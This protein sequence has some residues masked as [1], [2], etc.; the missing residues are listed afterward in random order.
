MSYDAHANFALAAVT[1]APIPAASGTSLFVSAAQA[2]LFP[3]APFN[4]TTWPNGVQPLAS[5]AEIVRVTTV[6]GGTG[7]LTIVRAQEG[8]TAKVIAAGWQIANTITAKVIEDIEA[9]AA[10]G[11]QGAQGLQGATGAQGLQGTTGLQGPQGDAGTQGFQG[12]Q[13]LQGSTGAQGA[14]GFQGSTGAQGS[15]GV[16]GAT[17][18]Q[19]AQGFQGTQGTQGFQGPQGLQGNQGFQGTQGNQG[20]QGT[21]G[22]SNAGSQTE[23]TPADPAATT[24]TT[25]VMM[26]L[27]GSITPTGSGNVLIVITGDSDNDTVNDGA[28]IGIR[29][30][31]GAAP[32][33]GAALTG[34]AVGSRPISNNANLALDI[35]RFPFAVAAV[36]TGLSV[37]TAY[38]VDASVAAVTGGT[39]RVRNLNIAI[40]E[41]GAG[42]Q[43]V[44]GTQGTQGNQ[45]S[46]GNQGTQGAQGVSGSQFV[47]S[48]G[49]SIT[50]TTLV[51]ITGLSIALTTGTWVIQAVLN[52]N[53]ATGTNGAQFG[54][55]YTGTV[56]SMD[57]NQLGQASTTTLAATARITAKN[58]ASTAVMTTSAAECRV[59]LDGQIVVSTSGTL[60]IQGL[61]V[62]SQTLTVRA[63]SYL[64]IYKV[65]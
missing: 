60:T 24:S 48:G 40:A 16:Q 13:G 23:A 64:R 17:G 4:A 14:Q 22:A 9:I 6:N 54:V 61:K 42:A 28:R 57:V 30:G 47:A 5:N 20:F 11:P 44:Q 33:N 41:I 37:G 63:G 31:T 7:E 3:A 56:T 8:T 32:A 26:G 27:A 62:S 53:A 10:P 58:T 15:Q 25:G 52:G 1:T 18:S 65:A 59:Q 45:G 51:D 19:G 29:Y 43:G 39:A 35:A 36:V 12:N 49:Q 2:A 38:W 21:P 46:Q 50:S 34:T 55:Q